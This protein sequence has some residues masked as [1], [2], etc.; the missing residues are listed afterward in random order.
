M[1]P[2][3]FRRRGH[4]LIY[5]LAQTRARIYAGE[6]PALA[7]I[8]PGSLRAALPDAPPQEQIGRAHV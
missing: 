1:T 8:A 6:V 5:W 3:E 7:Q 2:D 4:E